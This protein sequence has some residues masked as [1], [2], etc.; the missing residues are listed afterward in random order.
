MKFL[1]ILR[2]SALC[3]LAI[4]FR[5]P[6]GILCSNLEV[7]PYAESPTVEVSED[8]ED[9]TVESSSELSSPAPKSN[10]VFKNSE[11]D[12]SMLASTVL[13]LRQLC[14]DV[15][16]NTFTESL[17]DKKVCRDVT[18]ICGRLLIDLK[19]LTDHLMPMYGP[20]SV[21]KRKEIPKGLYKGVMKPEKFDAYLTWL[22]NNNSAIV[23]SFGDMSMEYEKLTKEQLK[24]ET[25]VGPLKYGF[26]FVDC[27]GS[28]TYKKTV[29]SIVEHCIGGMNSLL[30]R[31]DKILP[32]T[33]G[34]K[35]SYLKWL[36]IFI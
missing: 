36:S 6:R 25:T 21:D 12:D 28:F 31:L 33:Q 2:G 9:S 29:K 18:H 32:G 26:V 20:G 19:Y 23:K 22:A 7:N 35:T 1:G 11:W 4:G 3:L 17:S 15:R 14:R 10:L 5:G 16:G 24:T 34:K 30:V 13:F 8:H 27:L